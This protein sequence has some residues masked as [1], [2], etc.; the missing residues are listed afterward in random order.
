MKLGNPRVKNDENTS[1]KQDEYP[2]KNE[3]NEGTKQ[4]GIDKIQPLS[5][6]LFADSKMVNVLTAL[7]N[8]NK[9]N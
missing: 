7:V 5:Q 9:N 4:D 6:T 1:T 3:I 8:G 2:G